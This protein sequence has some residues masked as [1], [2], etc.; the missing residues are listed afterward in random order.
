MRRWIKTIIGKLIEKVESR[1]YRDCY[2]IDN[3]FISTQNFS[4]S[5][6]T[7]NGWA[8]T[9]FIHRTVPYQVYRLHCTGGYE[10]ECADIHK[11]I[12]IKNQERLVSELVPGDHIMTE[13]GPKMVFL[14]EKLPYKHC[15]Y[16]VMC[17]T[18]E[19]VYYTNGILSHNTISSSIYLAWYI[20]FNY[21]K[22]VF[23][24]GNIEKTAVDILGKVADVIKNV[25]FFMKP[26]IIKNSSLEW[27]FDNGCRLMGAATTKRAGIGF[28]IHCLYLDEF[29]HVD[30]G[31]IDEFFDNIYPTVS[32]L[33]DS[34]II[35]TSTPN[36]MNRFY[37]IYDAATKG[38]NSFKPFRIDWWQVPDWDKA[39]KRWKPRDDNWMKMQI[40][41]LGN[42]DDELGRE[43]FGA[44]YGNSFLSTGNLLLGPNALK[45]LE[46]D[47]EYFVKK[48]LAIFE[49]LDIPEAEYIK[50]KPDFEPE[51]AAMSND[52]FVFSIDLSEGNGGDN[53]ILN[54]FKMR[55]M[56]KEDWPNLLSPN[57]VR[58]FVGLEQVGIFAYNRIHLA[59]FAKILYVLSHKVFNCENTRIIL[60]W[61]AF[62]GE[63]YNAL[64]TVFG[65]RNDFDT[66][67]IVR[68]KRSVDNTRLEP[69]LRLTH[70]NKLIYCQN[71]KKN[72]GAGRMILHD[73]ET[74]QEFNLFGRKGSS[75]AA[76]TD[77]DDMAMS[78]IDANAFFDSRDFEWMSD[79]ELE[80]NPELF[81]EILKIIGEAD[82][83]QTDYKSLYSIGA[84]R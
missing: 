37:K 10:L 40:A 79:I 34:K 6:K 77:H 53:T 84:F 49:D 2:V 16:D 33:P 46:S 13:A 71:A 31:I 4:D 60:E 78:C 39:N 8:D 19:H 50:W 75:W 41:Q 36:G 81:S 63:V 61:N 62:G 66:S 47:K 22:T 35:V 56:K 55:V 27:K 21:D 64:K 45:R 76:I 9:M 26:G 24:C 83:N 48:P 15:M 44:Q 65:E 59:Q 23:L 7:E 70:D 30:K 3:K 54:V 32:S 82:N 57:S 67:V 18:P 69:G 12:D 5:V 72:I 28:T 68:F 58:D 17:N 52:M 11:V 29:A 20:L 73:D 14:V 1:L 42:G 43:R 38:I 25:P 51:E 80:R 74:I